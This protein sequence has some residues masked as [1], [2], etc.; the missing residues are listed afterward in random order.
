[1]KKILFIASILAFS[2]NSC[3]E[4]YQTIP[5]DKLKGSKWD[6]CCWG[7]DQKLHQNYEHWG[8]S[9]EFYGTS[10]SGVVEA[11]E[12]GDNGRVACL[13]EGSYSVDIEKQTITLR[14]KYNSNCPWT[15]K[16][17][18]TYQYRNLGKN[19]NYDISPKMKLS[20]SNGKLSFSKEIGVD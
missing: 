18:G 10:G 6:G 7:V 17:N 19:K 16:L 15:S 2:F 1:M 20:F 13:T 11:K 5:I 4:A 14:F 3:S 9:L 8:T 12:L